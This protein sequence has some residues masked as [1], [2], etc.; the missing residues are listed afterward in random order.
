MM[1]IQNMS[2]L[3]LL[4]CGALLAMVPDAIAQDRT[5]PERAGSDSRTIII[6]LDDDG[7]IL[8]DGEALG[9]ERD[10]VIRLGD[11]GAEVRVLRPEGWRERIVRSRVA[12]QRP[13]VDRRRHAVAIGD[14]SSAR[15]LFPFDF[16]PL[17]EGIETW[18]APLGERIEE[19]VEIA[20]MEHEARRLAREAR[21]ASGAERSRLQQ[22]LRESL[23]EIFDLKLDQRRLR[24]E[25][26]TEELEKQRN[27]LGQRSSARQE[28]IQRRINELMGEGDA[29]DW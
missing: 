18:A 6:E 10:V 17:I 5:A 7:R 28:I 29:L 23:D 12:T 25:R 16:E 14:L 20:R 19:H 8:I 24:V 9:E 11:R 15:A 3:S 26:L 4:L 21:N 2:I 22:D 13:D 1:T 27:L